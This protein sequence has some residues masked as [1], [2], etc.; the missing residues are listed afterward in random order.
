MADLIELKTAKYGGVEL[1]FKDMPTTGGNRLIKLNYPG[2]DKQSL[3][4]QGKAPRSFSLTIVI[5]HENYY[6][7]RDNILRVLEDGV[8]KVLV[9]PTF[10][11][12]NNVI[13]GI[14][15]L[16]E[17]ISELGRAEIVVPFEID[18]SIGIPI[19]SGDL[20]SQVQR[21]SDLCNAQITS[22][23]ADGY[24]VSLN[25][26]GNFDDAVE[27]LDN[28]V[29]VFE[30]A[31]SVTDA[32]AEKA[33]EFR[34]EVDA[35]SGNIVSLI[36]SPV[37]MA[38]SIFSLFESL[39][40]LFETPSETLGALSSVF[41]FGDSD[42][43]VQQ[44]TV[45]RVERKQNRDLV[46]SDMKLQ[47]LSYAYVNSS[48]IEYETT[49]ALDAAQDNLETQYLDIRNNQLVTNEA[50][51]QLDRLRVRG[52][53]ALES[54]RVNTRSIITIETD[55]KPLSVLLY[56]YY[57]NTDLFDT[58]AELNNIKQNAFVSGEVRIL[59]A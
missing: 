3:E 15:T 48:L 51:E 28:V 23:L 6:Q 59:T 41:N 34:A 58:I 18:D 11:D 17:R 12:V 29:S 2:S 9:H 52:Q 1:P 36:Q 27:N 54:A 42:P 21:E 57:G 26:T 20:P 22:D 44:T 33:S 47:A 14:Y 32:V 45:G 5:P 39:D 30:T 38:E 19:E 56:E 10:G 37:D 4:R 49:E 50:L 31:S 55:R 35:F 25:A 53:K 8:P 7:V 13:N 24:D 46:R 40:N 43:V 16:N